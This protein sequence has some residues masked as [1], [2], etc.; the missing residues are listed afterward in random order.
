VRPPASNWR[1]RVV[2]RAT[3][4]AAPVDAVDGFKAAVIGFLA[5]VARIGDAHRG[6]Y[7]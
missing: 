4:A 5:S 2:A 1:R 3:G 7:L 6:A